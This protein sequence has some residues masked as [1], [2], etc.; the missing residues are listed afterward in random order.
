M[1]ADAPSVTKNVPSG[2][3]DNL[4]KFNEDHVDRAKKNAGEF[5]K[6]LDDFSSGLV[7]ALKDFR[8]TRLVYD[9][10]NAGIRVGNG[11]ALNFY[12]N[13]YCVPPP[14]TS[15]G[16]LEDKLRQLDLSSCGSISFGICYPVKIFSGYRIASSLKEMFNAYLTW[17]AIANGDP[18]LYYADEVEWVESGGATGV[19]SNIDIGSGVTYRIFH[20]IGNG[21][22]INGDPYNFNP[23]RYYAF[24]SI[25][26][27]TGL[28]TRQSI[29]I[30][31]DSL[32]TSDGIKPE[33]YKLDVSLPYSVNSQCP[34]GRIPSDPPPPPT[35][36]ECDCM[37]CPEQE[38]KLSD[39]EHLLR[40]ILKRIGSLPA[41]VPDN[42]TKQNPPF[43][44]IESLAELAL[45]Q[46]QQLDAL[47]G[48]YPIEI[49]IEDSDSTKGGNQEEK[50]TIPNQA[51]AIAEM[52]GLM[53]T[54]KRDTHATLITA[55]KAM[56]EAG[57]GK[58]LGVK[59]LDVALANAEFLGYKLEQKKKKIP[60][61]FTPNGKN[62]EETLKEKEVEII[63]YEN[64]DKKD[65]QD[66]V[67][68]LL[69]TAA[70][71]N[72][73]NWRRVEGDP[74]ESLK[75]MLFG[76]VEAVAE[77]NT[78]IEQ[79]DFDSFTERAERGFTDIDGITDVDSPWGR[80]FTQR[81]KVR[82]IGTE[83]G[84]YDADGEEILKT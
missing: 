64:T 38:K 32:V 83:Q 80:P 43:I 11:G 59:T 20:G 29:N 54:I 84:R 46:M 2:V 31:L 1:L 3:L 35:P 12:R 22:N 6:K 26:E 7:D 17:S 55:I 79:D 68:K 28:K 48:A 70:R 66:D 23:P 42:F 8:N 19:I 5:F 44:N 62:I 73:Q 67:K 82:E 56:A 57:M 45:W 13:K 40:L 58:Q 74:V 4:R 61:L 25:I 27:I 16:S 72:A 15:S 77:Q 47:V 65:L 51:E 33:V 75:Q 71:W 30:I 18:Y 49:K 9:G 52:M 60:S 10:C 34:I 37:C 78:K 36:K 53:L 81:P 39:N 69:E 76:N 14:A 24:Q 21:C 41:N 50:I 63:T